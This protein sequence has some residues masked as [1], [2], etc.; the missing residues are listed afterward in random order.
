[1]LERAMS[2]TALIGRK[3]GMASVFD[4]S[5]AMVGVTVVD[6]RPNRVLALRTPERD[7]YEAVALAYGTRRATRARKPLAG[8]A[9][10][11]GFDETPAVVREVPAQTGAEV[12]VG[13]S[14]GVGDVFEVGAFV[15]VIGTSRGHGFSGVRKR[16]HFSYGPASHGSKN[17]REPGSTGQCTY[18]GRVFKG[19]R[20]AGQHGNVRRTVRNLRVVSVDAENGRLLVA[21][22]VPGADDTILVVRQAV[23]KRMPKARA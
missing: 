8:Q 12:S 4:D 16:H 7:G 21:G 2:V 9:K 13:D 18:P 10:A 5:G 14:I 23:A 19:K 3:A 15:D 1:M 22:P 6:I 17:Y 20:M 11:A